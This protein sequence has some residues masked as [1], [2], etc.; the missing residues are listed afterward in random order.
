MLKFQAVSN[1]SAKKQIL[2]VNMWMMYVLSELLHL[3]IIDGQDC[4]SVAHLAARMSLLL[5]TY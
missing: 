4:S 2:G 5:P 3:I 1:K